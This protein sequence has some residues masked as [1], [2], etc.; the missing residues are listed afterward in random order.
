MREIEHLKIC[1]KKIILQQNWGSPEKWTDQ[2]FI[3]LSEQIFDKSG[4]RISKNT[5]KNIFRERKD[6]NYNPQRATKE[7]LA[8]YLGYQDWRNF[9]QTNQ[10]KKGHK[11]PLPKSNSRNKNWWEVFAVVFIVILV[12]FAGFY[13]KKQNQPTQ[14]SYSFEAQNPVGF[15]PHTVSYRYDISD[16]PYDSV[17]LDH[18]YVHHK[19]GYQKILLNKNKN[20]INHCYQIPDNYLIRM[21]AENKI[22]ARTRI[23]VKSHGWIGLVSNTF[24][25]EME[26]KNHLKFPEF[27]HL[28]FNLYHT[29][30]NPVSDSML[31]ISPEKVANLGINPRFY[32]TEF[33]NIQKFSCPGDSATIEIKFKNRAEE[34]GISCF[35][36][37]FIIQCDT[38]FMK[39]TLVEPGC[40]R[41]ANAVIGGKMFSGETHDLSSFQHDFSRWRVLKIHTHKGK[42]SFYMDNNKFWEQ[43]YDLPLQQIKGLIFSFKGSGAIDYVCIKNN[44]QKIVYYE[45]FTSN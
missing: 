41:Y 43:H 6:Q 14:Y 17:F 31:Y 1:K 38:S 24:S 5:L 10:N 18:H 4:V 11:K 23:Q 2:D 39:I 25:D 9:K 42:V 40:Y 29:F 3:S 28:I 16:L 37:Q 27:K 30:P 22:L 15:A 35:D 36:S 20:L 45:D 21:M 32:W 12:A 8:K 44:L 13:I 26:T 34:G 19:M 7:A 33:R